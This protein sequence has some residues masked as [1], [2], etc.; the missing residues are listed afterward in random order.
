MR[1]PVMGARPNVLSVDPLSIIRGALVGAQLQVSIAQVGAIYERVVL[2]QLSLYGTLTP[3]ITSGT[4]PVI[5]GVMGG[6]RWYVVGGAPAG[7]WVGGQLGLLPM[8][9]GP[10][11][12]LEGGYQWIL[13]NG[14]ALGINA[15]IEM[16]EDL[17]TAGNLAIRPMLA[18]NVGWN[19]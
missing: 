2:P 12:H 14:L 19:F 16:G 8:N 4:P 18:G 3:G 6:V 9:L 13:D 5:L 1:A 15:R 10:G 11:V 7:P 17:V